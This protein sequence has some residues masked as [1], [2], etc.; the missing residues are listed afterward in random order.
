MQEYWK[1]IWP[2]LDAIP[3]SERSEYTDGEICEALEVYRNQ[4]IDDSIRSENQLVKMFA[5]LDRR[6]GRRTLLKLKETMEA[7]PTW[8]QQIYTVRL[9]A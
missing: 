6:A 9:E 2:L 5:L 1:E 3:M 7:Q 4:Q 8:L